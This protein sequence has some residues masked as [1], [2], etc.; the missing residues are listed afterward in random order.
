[1]P[2][3]E[4]LPEPYIQ[5]A[6]GVYLL[7]SQHRLV[8]SLKKIYEPSVHGHKAWLSSYTLMDYLLHKPFRRGVRVM[9]I[10]CGWGPAGIFCAKKFNARVTGVDI[11]KDVFPFL[12]VLAELNEVKV[13]TLVSKF[14]D[15]TVKRLSEERI[16]IGSDICF[17]DEMV[18]P[19]FNLIQRAMKAGVERVI[20]ADPGRPTFYELADLCR[21]K[22]AVE[23]QEWYA[24]EPNYTSGEVME[25]RAK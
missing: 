22:F 8:R 9:E 20:I 10:G 18:K 23:L 16:V 25:V 15:L 14:E 3:L 7:Q 19:L 11:D 24:V 17:W 12:E 21:E 2:K 6:Y 5:Q 13:R 4:R 1:M